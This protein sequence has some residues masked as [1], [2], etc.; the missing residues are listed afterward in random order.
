METTTLSNR[1]LKIDGMTGDVCVQKVTDALK[2]V[3]GV[4]TE[5]V[6]VG[7]ATIGADQAGCNAACGALGK[8][9]FKAH[10]GARADSTG[11]ATRPAADTASGHK[12][13]N[14]THQSGGG[15][16]GASR[17]QPASG[18][19]AKA[20]AIP[21]DSRMSTE[22]PARADTHAKSDADDATMHAEGPNAGSRPSGS[23]P[24]KPV[25]LAT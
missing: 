3:P 4:K 25:K 8:A 14:P 24:V 22:K 6:K 13:A 23:M 9:G 1:T 20:S 15:Q 10:E 11:G 21:A 17:S 12:G 2:G 5:S 7:C 19:P 18:T 16:T